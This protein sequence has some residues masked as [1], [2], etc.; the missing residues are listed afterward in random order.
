M[1]RDTSHEELLG[2]FQGEHRG[3]VLWDEG[4]VV[5]A[6]DLLSATPKFYPKRRA[7]QEVFFESA[8]F[9]YFADGR[10]RDQIVKVALIV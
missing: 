1:P 10:S 3:D 2:C 9:Q 7:K 6:A 4:S 5:N 8:T